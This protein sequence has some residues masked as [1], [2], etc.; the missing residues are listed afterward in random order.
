M[1]RRTMPLAR[2]LLRTEVHTYAFSVA[3]NVILSFFPFMVLMLV[4]IRKV[5]H[6]AAMRQVVEQLLHDYLPTNQ[7]FVIRNIKA[8]AYSHNRAAFISLFILLVTSTGVFLPLEVALNQV[9][10]FPKNRPYWKNQLVSV[11]LA[12]VSGVLALLSIALTAG[13]RALIQAIAGRYSFT[14]DA[15]TLLFA[16]VFAAIATIAIFF[17]IYWLL[18]NGK[19]PPG[20]ALSA[21]VYVGLLWEMAKYLYILLLPWLNFPEVYG[22]F[23][24]SVTLIMWAFLSGLLLLAGA[25]LSAGGDHPISTAKD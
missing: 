19:V 9:W 21:A 17:L 25:Y 24:V 13:N 23:S 8:I 10:G 7:D 5:F 2:Y 20:A 12:F 16:K 14:T 22:P 11:G 3:A 6:S 18:P 4:V 15:V 1:G